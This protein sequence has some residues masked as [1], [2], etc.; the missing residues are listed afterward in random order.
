MIRIRIEQGMMQAQ[1][2]AELAD[3]KVVKY[4]Q[5]FGCNGCLNKYNYYY[6]N[7]LFILRKAKV[8]T[9]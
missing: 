9:T 3:M 8:K 4:I 7:K 2:K 1:V 6:G 5:P